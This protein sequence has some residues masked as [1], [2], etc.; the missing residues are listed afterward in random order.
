MTRLLPPGAH[1]D[2]AFVLRTL[3]NEQRKRIVARLDAVRTAP[4]LSNTR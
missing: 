2:G 4:Y 1:D 3:M